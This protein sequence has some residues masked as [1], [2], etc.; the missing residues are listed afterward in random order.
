[1]SVENV[2]IRNRHV[3]IGDLRK[4]IKVFTRSITPPPF[5]VTDFDEDFEPDA[6]VWAAVNTING[7]TFF[8]GVSIVD[9]A[10]THEVFIRYRS[11]VD[12]DT[13]LELDNRR[14]KIVSFEIMDESKEWLRLLCAERGDNTIQA[15]KA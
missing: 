8:D 7:K 15:T 6:T 5:G 10:L 1:M 2:R 4:R 11:D 12:S 13:W 3:C 14:L 9:V